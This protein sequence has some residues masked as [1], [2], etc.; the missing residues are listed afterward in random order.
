M[1][2]GE[3]ASSQQRRFATRNACAWSGEGSPFQGAG[4]SCLDL[5][6]VVGLQKHSAVA[7]EPLTPGEDASNLGRSE[8]ENAEARSNGAETAAEQ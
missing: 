7:A 6:R 5:G 1:A 3:N 4:D 2:A 8:G